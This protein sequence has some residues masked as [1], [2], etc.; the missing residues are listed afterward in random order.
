[1]KPKVERKKET[2]S[3]E[4]WLEFVN[5]NLFTCGRRYA[6]VFWIGVQR[7]PRMPLKKNPLWRLPSSFYVLLH[8]YIYM[9]IYIYI[10]IKNK[11][12]Y[13]YICMYINSS[14]YL[15]VYICMC[16][17][18]YTQIHICTYMTV[19]TR[20]CWWRLRNSEI[21]RSWAHIRVCAYVCV[22]VYIYKYMNI[23]MYIYI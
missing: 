11:H 22:C 12:I 14:K 16:I 4:S 19:Y 6:R 17:Y 1:M 5:L 2:S 20:G 10:C 23:Y 15:Y 8:I 21:M 9:C 3:V 13:I 18:I 7:I